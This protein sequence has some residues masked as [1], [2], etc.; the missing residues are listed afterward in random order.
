MLDGG[1]GQRRKVM[2]LNGLDIGQFQADQEA[3][4]SS[5]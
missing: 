5:T 2:Q 4:L 1:L 3:T